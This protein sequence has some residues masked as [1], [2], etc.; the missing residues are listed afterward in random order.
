MQHL[1]KWNIMKTP[2]QYDPKTG[3]T[4][5]DKEDNRITNEQEQQEIVNGDIPD[6]DESGTTGTNT[7]ESQEQQQ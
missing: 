3:N 2:F 1:I 6:K 7:D 4:D 5:I